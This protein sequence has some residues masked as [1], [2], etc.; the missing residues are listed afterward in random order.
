MNELQ[1]RVEALKLHG[2]MAHWE[3]ISEE[4]WLA[5]LVEWEETE[6]VRRGLERRLKR[7]RLGTFKP[8]ADFDWS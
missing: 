3:E 1:E 7:A 4:P 6:R 5:P 2:L 8:L